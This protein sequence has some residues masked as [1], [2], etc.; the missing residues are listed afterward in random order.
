MS[1]MPW[2]SSSAARPCRSLAGGQELLVSVARFARHQ[3]RT[4][5][6]VQGG[7]QSGRAVASVVVGDT[8][9]LAEPIGSI[10][11]VRSSAWHRLF[12]SRRSPVRCPSG[13]VHANVALLLDENGALDSLKPS[14]RCGCKPRSW[15]Y[16]HA[17]LELTLMLE[18]SFWSDSLCKQLGGSRA[19]LKF[20]DARVR[21]GFASTGPAVGTSLWLAPDRLG[22]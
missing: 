11:C 5:E 18:G 21:D 22:F 14:V 13:W 12:S 19:I 20:F 6:Q 4:V 2:M 15:K 16:L 1:A 9:G 8:F 17:G 10:G 7:K 3:R